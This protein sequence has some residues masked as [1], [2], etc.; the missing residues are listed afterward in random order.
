MSELDRRTGVKRLQVR[1]FTLERTMYFAG[2]LIW[3]PV[4][5][6]D[7]GGEF[8]WG[9]RENKNGAVGTARRIQFSTKY[10]F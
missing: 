10:L 7:I 8:L 4:K 9:Q 3:S 2:N 6:M 1:R 5:Q